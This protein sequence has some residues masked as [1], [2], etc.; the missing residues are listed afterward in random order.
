VYRDKESCR[1]LCAFSCAAST[2]LRTMANIHHDEHAPEF[3]MYLFKRISSF[4]FGLFGAWFGFLYFISSDIGKVT[5]TFFWPLGALPWQ[6]FIRTGSWLAA[7]GPLF[8]CAF[9]ILNIP[10][11]CARYYLY[12]WQSITA[13]YKTLTGVSK[14]INIF[15]YRFWLI[16]AIR[17]NLSFFKEKEKDFHYYRGY[18]QSSIRGVFQSFLQ[19]A[20]TRMNLNRHQQSFPVP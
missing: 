9:L 4:T 15:K 1:C 12:T 20:K 16:P 7:L 10:I 2:R 3:A 6:V 17:C 19:N 13:N 18:I 5:L 14:L 11:I 8:L